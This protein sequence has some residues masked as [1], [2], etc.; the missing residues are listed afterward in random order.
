M[1]LAITGKQ[2]GMTSIFCPYKKKWMS[3]SSFE[4]SDRP[5]PGLGQIQS[6]GSGRITWFGLDPV[7][8]PSPETK[9]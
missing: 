1:L 7:S 5:S 2:Y 4:A 8:L 9:N 3:N 6:F